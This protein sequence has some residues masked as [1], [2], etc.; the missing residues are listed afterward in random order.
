MTP[1][2]HPTKAKPRGKAMTPKRK[3]APPVWLLVSARGSVASTFFHP[4]YANR[5]RDEYNANDPW[6]RWEV[7]EYRPVARRSSR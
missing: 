7:V 2:P 3:P 6:H 4:R 5:E 1:H